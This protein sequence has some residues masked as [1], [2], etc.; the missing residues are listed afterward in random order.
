MMTNQKSA[1]FTKQQTIN[2]INTFHDEIKDLY[3]NEK[4]KKIVRKILEKY[5]D[6]NIDFHL[7]KGSS[8]VLIKYS[9]DEIFMAF[10]NVASDIK[11]VSYQ[12]LIG[13][14]LLYK[15]R[16]V[17]LDIKIK[18]IIINNIKNESGNEVL[19]WINY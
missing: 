15:M 8:N 17:K 12:R 11:S 16:L 18:F 1:D 14:M 9:N 19:K 6:L 3:Y 4:D 13:Y 5:L 2:S 10:I 7:I